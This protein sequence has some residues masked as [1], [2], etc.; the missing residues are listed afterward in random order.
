MNYSFG[1][2]K[3]SVYQG[4]IIV[5]FLIFVNRML[6]KNLHKIQ[7]I[8]FHKLSIFR[9]ADDKIEG[10]KYLQQQNML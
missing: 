10:R 5:F 7:Q 4:S 3:I 2:K 1:F 9:T 6:V 8:T